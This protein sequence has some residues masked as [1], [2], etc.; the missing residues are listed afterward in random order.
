MPETVKHFTQG[1]CVRHGVRLPGCA[2]KFSAWY[3]ENGNLLDA[4]RIDARGR[5]HLP[6]AA[7]RKALSA[8]TPAQENQG[9][10]NAQNKIL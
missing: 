8:W 9:G 2:S 7:Q 6:T 3:D 10:R 5:S 4:D 1:G